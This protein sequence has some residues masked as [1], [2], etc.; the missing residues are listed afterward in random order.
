VEPL[1]NDTPLY[2]V[3]WEA[4]RE[5]RRGYDPSKINAVLLVTDGKNDYL[6]DQSLPQLTKDL[7]IQMG[8]R[9]PVRVFSI[10]YAEADQDTL[11]QISQASQAQAYSAK[12]PT[13]IDRVFQDVMSNF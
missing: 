1:Q 2:W 6:P 9:T 8:Q 11:E 5:V 3:T 13:T 7:G 10:G 4:V 12:D